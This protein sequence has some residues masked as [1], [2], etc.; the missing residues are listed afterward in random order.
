MSDLIIDL[1]AGGG[2]A[3]LGIFWA[4]GRHPDIAI[5]HD[6]DAVDM[7]R[8]NHPATRHYCQSIA[9]VDPAHA[10]AEFPGRRV[11]LL[12]ASPD[13]THHS[14]AR[15][16]KPVRKNIRSLAWH[17]VRWVAAI[18]R[19]T[20]APPAVVALENVEE[21][22]DWGPLGRD[23]RPIKARRGETF[24]LWTAQLEA[25]G[26][27]VEYAELVA[28]EFGVPTTRKRLF[29]IARFDGVAIT[30]PRPSHA[31]PEKLVDLF[32]P[33]LAAWRPA[34]DCVDWSLPCPSIFN[35]KRSLAPKTLSRIAKGVKR[36]VIDTAR[37]FIVPITHTGGERVHGIDEPLR[38]VTS[39]NRGEFSLI[40]PMVI[41]TGF[42]ASRMPG[43][44]DVTGPLTTITSQ[45]AHGIAAVHLGRQ[46]GSTVSGRSIEDP[47]PTVV[48]GGGGS[49][50]KLVAAHLA[51]QFGRSV[52]SDPSDPLGTVMP[53]GG[54]KTQL[55][56]V[57]LDAYY[58]TGV[59]A[60]AA[61]PLRTITALPRHG[62]TA[63]FV[64]QAN[65][66]MVG[67]DAREPLSTICGRGTQQRP[68]MIALEDV[69]G[70][71]GSRRAAVLAFLQSHFG[72]PTAAERADPLA[73]PLARLKFGLVLIDG[74]IWRISDIGMRMLVPREL[75]AAQ[76]FPPE[77]VIEVTL[78]GRRLT[79]TS[80][81][82]K[83]G[84]SVCPPVAQAIIAANCAW[85]SETARKVA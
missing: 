23:N 52:G 74:E 38:T 13:C 36:Y 73:S 49:K 81:T 67:H 31:A 35:R 79:K 39:A 30:W 21:F 47:H 83:A 17:V 82:A 14:K 22:Q 84:N 75:F 24:R 56:A 16:G 77:Y 25:L 32:A 28:A 72:A 6:R 68:V 40:S 20:G 19:V 11:G 44:Y 10:L 53:G 58:A 15:G 46:F 34:A 80:Q 26:G 65:G 4:T 5:N 7:H 37:P 45:L 41:R 71:P 48:A 57:S 55:A 42:K 70:E 51:R 64:E 9:E 61:E 18:R 54:G 33:A 29:L 85:L 50:S 60:S 1:F 43:A 63:A 2:G 78:E 66:G 69:D 8:A 3:S 59:P 62:L 27:R 76:G 12:W